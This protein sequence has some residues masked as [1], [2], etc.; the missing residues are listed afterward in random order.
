M[1]TCLSAGAYNTSIVASTSRMFSRRQVDAKSQSFGSIHSSQSA[2]AVWFDEPPPADA[3]PPPRRGSS[4][5]HPPRTPSPPP[6]VETDSVDREESG[7]R[8]CREP[9]PPGDQASVPLLPR[10]VGRRSTSS[11]AV[12]ATASTALIADCSPDRRSL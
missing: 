3:V 10:T 6:M 8:P 12:A 1:I 11:D 2:P 5:R 7:S 9:S 4:V